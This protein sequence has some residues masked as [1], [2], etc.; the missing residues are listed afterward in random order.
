MIPKGSYQDKE[1]EKQNNSAEN[2]AK[3]PRLVFGST[4]RTGFCRLG[5]ICTTGFA[6]NHLRHYSTPLQ[7]D[8]F[9]PH[10]SLIY[11]TID[12]GVDG[13]SAIL[14]MLSDLF[15]LAF[16]HSNGDT[17]KVFF[18]PTPVSFLPRFCIFL[19]HFRSSFRLL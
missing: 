18:I 6:L 5:N 9:I 15:S 13:L 17:V 10:H 16:R 14:G 8:L 2:N 3:S 12:K 19:R 4:M 7:I 11:G 1:A